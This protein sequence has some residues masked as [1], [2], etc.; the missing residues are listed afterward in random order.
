VLN[1]FPDDPEVRQI[2]QVLFP[3]F[4]VRMLSSPAAVKSSF[5]VTGIFFKSSTLWTS[6][7]DKPAALN[8]AR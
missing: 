1:G 6:S 2:K 8:K 4:L 5:A 3:V 7:G